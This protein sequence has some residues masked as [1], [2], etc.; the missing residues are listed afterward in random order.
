MIP[1]S[2]AQRRVW[3]LVQLEGPSPTWN[4]PLVVPLA[5]DVDVAALN[6]A[7]RDVIIRHESLRTVFPA[8]DG[9][10]YQRILDP[11]EL[12]WELE[13][14]RIAPGEAVQAADRAVW[15]AF[16]LASEVPIRAWLFQEV[17]DEPE[18]GPG[19]C[20][21]VVLVH[22]IAADGWSLA[23]LSR[24]V[25]TAYAARVRG[26]A[27][28]WEPLPVQYADYALWQRE[29]LGDES[30][31]ESVLSV[32]IDY[33][34]RA[35]A[36]IPEELPLPTD[37]PRPAVAGHR[38]HAVPVRIPAE[39]HQRLMDLARAEG[40]TTFMVLQAALA[41]T[42]FRLGASTDIP[43]G[44]AVA[45]RTD[46]A[47]ND[48]VGF[49][50]NTLVV[51]TDLS[52]DPQFRQ[53]LARV[54]EAGLSAL[55]HQDVP[56]ERLVEELAPGRSL[57]RHPLFQV[58]LNVQTTRRTEP[59]G[60]PAADRL[61]LVPAKFDLELSLREALDAWGRAAGIH[62][63]LIIAA[64][65]F[66]TATGEALA[67]RWTRVL[68]AVTTAPDVR[69]HEVDVLDPH[70]RALLLD[71]WNTAATGVADSTI[72]ELVE[73]RAAAAPDAVA[74]V[75]DGTELT[76]AELDA[77][78][79]RLARYLRGRGVGAESVVAVL[80]ERGPDIV[81]AMLAVLKAGGAY[82][83][84]DPRYPAE[85][86]AYVLA[87][88]G[89]AGVLT[90]AE[91]LPL[92]AGRAP[93][94][95]EVTVLDDPAVTAELAGL[96][97][98]AVSAAALPDHPAYVIYTSG[99]TG[100]PKGV[101]VS[102]R[103]V[104]GLFAA[105]RELFDLGP[106]D[107]WSCFHSFAF[108]FSV[109]E[110]WGALV[111]GARVVI[112]P[113]E[114]SRSP[115]RFA[116]TLE[117]E[118]VTVLSQTPSAMYQLLAAEEFT[119]GALRL[120]VFGGEALDPARL[121]AWWARWPDGDGA[122]LVNMY[123]ITE[124]TV[125]VTHRRLGPG[126]QELG[127]VVGRGIPGWSTYLLDETL[128]PVP[129]GVV[130]ELYV[131]GTGVAR[132]Y[133]GRPGLTAERFVACP[134]GTG[135]RMYR[136]GDLAKWTPD[137]Q[138]VFAGRADD[139]VKIR[140]FRIEPGEIEAALLAHPDVTQ[141]AVVA[142]EDTPGDRRLVAYVVA[143]DDGAADGLREF[144][145][146]RLPEY[147]V[148]AAVVVLDELPLTPNGKLDRN[149]LPAPQYV[150]GQGRRPVTAR[151][152]ILCGVFA[153]VLGV[154]SVG[155][156]DDFFALGGH[157]L[158]AA[159]LAS[160]I[161]A[162]LDVELPLWML[163]EAP[164]V[165][166]LA[167]RIAGS[168][169]EQARPALRAGERS[170]RV[171]L[172]FAQR[173]LWFLEQLE[174]PSPTYNLP[175]VV[176]LSGGL[177][178]AALDAALRDVIGRHESLRTV[179]PSADGEPYQRIMD[180]GD[181]DWA[182][183]VRRVEPGE[184]GEAVARA[185]RYAFD[186]ASEVPIRAWLFEPGSEERVLVV[187]IH[188]I[189]TDGWSHRP[190]GRD[191]SVAYAA[192]L[193]GEA[194]QWDPLPVQYADYALWQRELL[195]EESDP[196]SLLSAQVEYWRQALAGAPEELPL[197]TDRPRPAV[198]SHRGYRAPLQV[199]ADVHERLVELAR[200]EGA[201]TFMVLQ[202][203]LAVT[204]S[205]LGAGT[206]IPIGSA[207]AGRGD[208]AL[209][210]L[211][212]FFVNTLVI[213]TDLS[214][215]PEFR[216]VLAQVRETT[217]GALEH[218]DVPFERLVEELAPERSLARHPLFQVMLTVQ[219]TDRAALDLAGTAIDNDMP[220]ATEPTEVPAKFDLDVAVREV[221][222]EQGRPA[223]L[224]GSVTVSADLFEMA[225]AAGLAE[226]WGRVLETVSEVPDVRL[227][228]VDVLDA[229]ERRLVL[230]EWNDTAAAVPEGTVLELFERW[231]ADAPDAVAVVHD[232]VRVTYA[233]L[234]A[235]ANRIA[236]HLRGLGVGAESLV[237]LY[238]PR[239]VD[240]VAAMLGVWKAGAAYLPIDPV[241]PAERVEFLLADSR[242]VALVTTGDLL[243]DVSVADVP[244]IA[245]EEA[246][247]A[248]AVEAVPSVP[249][250]PR[251][252]AYVI[253][254]S[255]STG[256]PKGVAVAHASLVN[257][258]S[259]FG[260]L[261][262]AGPGVGVL[263]FASFGFDASVLDVA[264][265]LSCGAT[266]WVAGER[267]R[268][269]PR[270]VDALDGVGVASVVPSVLEVVDPEDWAGVR[271]LLV[272][273][274]AIS[275]A[276]ARAWSVGRNLVN[277]YGP[278]EATVMVACGAV[279]PDRDGPVPFGRPIANTRLYVLDEALAPAPVGV[280]GELY[281]AGAGLARGYVG[282][283]GLTGERFV[284]CPFGSGERMYRT[285]DLARWTPDGQLVFA[286]R[287]DEQI[288]IRGFRIEPGEVEAALLAHP[289][290]SQAAVLAREDTPGEKR[291]VAYVVPA[292][293]ARPGAEVLRE[294][295]ARRLPEY[296]VPA[297]VVTLDELPLTVN[298]KLD[299][300]VLPA[301]EYST[302]AGRA[303]ATVQEEILCAA[304]AQVLGVE[305]V[306]VDDDFFRLGGHSL[307]AVRLVSRIRAALGVEVPLRAL[308]EAP[309]VARLAARLAEE[310]GR[311]RLPLRAGERP[312]RVPLSFAQRRLWFLHQL[313]GP[314]TTYNIPV[315]VRLT[316][317]VDVAS[318]EAALRD[319]IGRHES[320][321]TVFPSV[322]GEPYQRIVDPAEL[323]WHL[324]VRDVEPGELADAIAQ[325]T[326]YAFDLSAE[327][328]IRAWLFQAGTDERVLVVIVHHIAGDGWSMV[329][330]GRDVSMAYAARVRGEAPEWEPLPVQY[331]D[332]ALWQREL[333]GEESDPDS[334]LSAQVE[335]WRRV[336]AGMPEELALPTD[337]PRPAA[338]THRG[339]QVPVQLPAELHERLVELARTEGATS[340]MVLQA[341]LAVALSRLG[342][343]TD[344]PIG[345]AVAG[346]TDESLDDL[347]GFF[348]NTLVIRTDLS[349]D[350]QFREV[351]AR[352]RETTLGA[353][354]H[355]D[356]P[357]ERLVEELAP[358]RSLAR[359]PL[360]QV[361]L[362][363]QNTD[364][365][366]LDLPN[367]VAGPAPLDGATTAAR[368]DLEVSLA[369]TFDEQ[370]R[371]TGVRGWMTGSVDLFDA[372]SVEAMAR[373]WV[374]V[375]ETVSEAPDVRLHAVNVLDAEERRLV[376]DQWNDTAATVP[377]G[378][379]LEL[380]ARQ[381]AA[382]PDAV[383]LVHEGSRVEY[384]ELDARADRFARRLR[385]LGVGPE[386]VVGLCL[387]RGVDVVAAILG[388]WKAGAAYL[389]I[390]P[391]NPAERVE[392][393]LADSR[394]VALVTTGDLLEDVSVADVPVVTVEDLGAVDAVE[395]VP[396]AQVDPR[397]LAY[398]IYT[399]GSTGRPKGVAV[400]HASLVNLVSVFGPVMGAG[401]GV[402][403]LQFAS[404]GFD[405]SV[406]DVAVALSHG[407]TLWVA[408]DEQRSQPRLLRELSEVSVA[409][410]VPS[411]LGVLEPDDL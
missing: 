111:H 13:V 198:T 309:T 28:D 246:C 119:P 200:A 239:G 98:T 406:L 327:V 173:R 184:L 168:D 346:R 109:W 23:P 76:Y 104:V 382:V 160:R 249:V 306:G 138:L 275:G 218:Q 196:D 129:V 58:A 358:E 213:R 183:E 154:P 288:K 374:R 80:M 187:V 394:A 1:L 231:V 248:D 279:D 59:G 25:T 215:D 399:S 236:H 290:V 36:G 354:A 51:R 87:D 66:D 362:T 11:Q 100:R 385:G 15:H 195:G 20:L 12:D 313:E 303:P 379:V 35:L 255:G 377:D 298:G 72:A 242:A 57:A 230:D 304:F 202:A 181:L 297:A 342:A 390:D 237:G 29:L 375:L 208:E 353:F 335:Y 264:V 146:E 314:N 150:T 99:S 395:A 325:V 33:W 7:L 261:M 404:F 318:L 133:V 233:E 220:P 329:P 269:E 221:F 54:R 52:G 376:L 44:V 238:L 73:R 101:A 336:L 94:D 148:P 410:V 182:L 136:T 235:R 257:L 65:L 74:V 381:V 50:V 95:V 365:A 155:V 128:T 348:V 333:L 287:A 317:D 108:D 206:D 387:P 3:F 223:G 409:S 8:V 284:A 6:A 307:L 67:R 175:M 41:V 103:N 296:M 241:S 127:S 368:F 114:V 340:F 71:G 118:R 45:G 240:V 366:V 373:R 227:R 113:F 253:Y 169:V 407:A 265:V 386:S 347:V 194:P 252:L 301:P 351:L 197:P 322:E 143:A 124:T 397:G 268:S 105:T 308:F 137:G 295:V 334:L 400:A 166:G 316:G 291:L 69:L 85:R 247:S 403:V 126:D 352:V 272:G 338:A 225:S 40:A 388:V 276:V 86:V 224:R 207:V 260:P 299:R 405:A 371:P 63:S 135:E 310:T 116:E 258:V 97:G 110:L 177:D 244:V 53:V 159:R 142:R 56:F 112:V 64:D 165:A 271:T 349:G 281:I 408:G 254:T 266:L 174:G 77:R 39:T 243:E 17:P 270:L 164:T 357:F 315:P 170:E 193:R 22:H 380:F 106:D 68:D 245:L 250:D 62:G 292:G 78:A 259:V 331:A 199:S 285:G 91:H 10:P 89:V 162:V 102:H 9:E 55:E 234:D 319:V 212:G 222:D 282:R 323:E 337:R 359:H 38:G 134:F 31:P 372:E 32:Q 256:R 210:D 326:R 172:S 369:E 278:T 34:R 344:I 125:H 4:I 188:H 161:R 156:D 367:V 47:L 79:N 70:E 144:A 171:P 201:T 391:V 262:G 75:A 320:L 360:F 19:E 363:V 355:Q 392:F 178:V 179:F 83:P 273:A 311:A 176:R 88:A 396:P 117:R 139:Q 132:G 26:K 107:V 324:E 217:L 211:V 27:P 120:V 163:F 205:R 192:R 343:G 370:G 204:L 384:G 96:D 361:M 30:D 37:R 293:D 393:L 219:N 328:P 152:E 123:G 332:Y 24:D 226:R 383:A 16:D 289:D 209:N 93:A 157:S 185:T 339:H 401:P 364:R 294:H 302:G 411:L 153:D 402:G 263:Q 84:V 232:G 5:G 286:G 48:L 190:L 283:A 277:T 341:A 350:P 14:R 42:L 18:A 189:A 49:F 321:R 378:T 203:A 167:A 130:G 140:G 228:A 229:E 158:L 214:G 389:P 151:E 121:D 141:A 81:V 345:A 90:S 180:V 186:L 300:K 43:I 115:V 82:L 251:G 267:E 145:A 398:V 21:L 280:V 330:L 356:V 122:A 191:L 149:A 92:V 274:E 216:Q 305:S 60:A 2:F 131:A 147:M 46:E 312:E 61:S